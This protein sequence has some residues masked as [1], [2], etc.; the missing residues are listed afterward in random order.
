MNAVLTGLDALLCIMVVLAALEYLRAVDMLKHPILASAFYLVAIGAFG[1]LVELMTGGVAS[2]FSVVLHL[3]VVIY[4]WA[5]RQYI[6]TQDAAWHGHD[7][8]KAHR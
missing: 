1:L 3:G 5:R 8:R 7:R 4:A 6:F 2:P